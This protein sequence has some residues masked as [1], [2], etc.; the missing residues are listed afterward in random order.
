MSLSWCERH[1][2]NSYPTPNNNYQLLWLDLLCTV[3]SSKSTQR[4][5]APSQPVSPE[6]AVSRRSWPR[7]GAACALPVHLLACVSSA[8][9]SNRAQAAHHA[10]AKLEVQE[11][12]SYMKD[13][14][15]FEAL[16]AR[17]PRGV[18]FHGV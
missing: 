8:Q 3:A 12:V 10:Q 2:T 5:W 9:F 6:R 11:L 18:L 14:S 17:F 13:P 15:R 7:A 4:G 16:G 1:F